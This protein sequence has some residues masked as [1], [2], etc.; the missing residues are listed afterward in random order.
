MRSSTRVTFVV[1]SIRYVPIH[2]RSCWFIFAGCLTLTLFKLYTRQWEIKLSLFG[3]GVLPR[4]LLPSL[5]STYHGY[6][7]QLLLSHFPSKQKKM[8]RTIS[9]WIVNNVCAQGILESGKST[10]NKIAAML[11][12]LV[13]R[14]YS[15]EAHESWCDGFMICT[16]SFRHRDI[17]GNINI[18]I[19]GLR[20]DI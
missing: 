17:K 13:W 16:L 11:F 5:L 10:V 18:N 6:C 1:N 9:C 20:L 7:V 2:L 19:L 3:Q 4:A 12:H 14:L 15:S 8:R